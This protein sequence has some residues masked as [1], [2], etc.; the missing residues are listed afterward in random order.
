MLR[1]CQRELEEDQQQVFTDQGRLKPDEEEMRRLRRERV[2]EEE[3]HPKESAGDL[4]GWYGFGISFLHSETVAASEY[5]GRANQQ[6]NGKA[7]SAV[8][9]LWRS[10]F[11]NTEV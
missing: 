9:G 4:L 6:F 1:R 5:L 11:C 2:R 8:G 3:G 10:G 7:A